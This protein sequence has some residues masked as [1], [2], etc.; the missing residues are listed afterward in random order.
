M[1]F[2]KKAFKNMYQ[3]V[4]FNFVST[5][6]AFCFLFLNL[7]EKMRNKK[8]DFYRNLLFFKFSKINW[9]V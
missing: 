8:R 3:R 9:S 4:F 7:Y 2:E 6:Y 1:K 5:N